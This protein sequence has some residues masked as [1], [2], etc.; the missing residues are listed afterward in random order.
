MHSYIVGNA[1]FT[2]ITEGV[3]RMEYA[4]NRS[5]VD[6][7][8]L[9][10]VRKNFFDADFFEENGTLTVKT[11]KFTLKYTDNGPFTAENLTCRIHTGGVDKIWHYGDSLSNN[12]FGTLVTLDGVNGERPLPDGI[13]SRDGFYVFDDSAK[14]VIFEGWIK[15]RSED[16]V[17]DIYLFAY[18]KDY[19]SALRDLSSVSG[20]FELPRRCIFGSWYSRWWKYTADE[21][22][23]I[24]DEYEKND[25]PLDIM[26][27]DMDWHYQDWGRNEGEPLALYGYGHCGQNLGWTG[28]T[29]NKTVIPDPPALISK[30]KSRGIKTVLNDHPADGLRDHDDGY[31]EFIEELSANGYTEEVPDI[32]SLISERE[33]KNMDRNVKNFRFNAG[34][35][36]YMDAFF[37]HALSRIEKD[38]AEF[39]WLDWQQDYIYPTVNKIK[40][41]PHLPWLNHLYYEHSK[42]GNKRGASFSRWGGI[43]D[44]KHPAY[45]SGDAVSSWETLAFEIKMTATA[46]NAGCFWWSHDIGGFVDYVEGGQAENYVRWVQFGA[47]SA[48]LRLH[49]NGVEGF[50][51]RPWTWGEPYCSAMREAFHLRSKLFPYI[52]SSAYT[53]YKKSLPFIRP[54]Y[55]ESPE[56][57]EAYEHPYTY[58]LGEHMIAS[59][60]VAPMDGD[61]AVT[62]LWLP[63]GEWVDIF[64]GKRYKSGN[65]EIEN[66]LFSFPL[67]VKVGVPFVTRPYCSRM[68]TEPYGELNIDIYTGESAEGISS[69]YEDDGESEEF[70]LGKCRITRMR[71]FSK[72]GEH[73]L[74]L[75]P[76]GIF[77]GAIENR[78]LKITFHNVGENNEFSASAEFEAAYENGNATV[79]FK[80]ISANEELEIILKTLK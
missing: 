42:N 79:I 52:Y 3:I 51:R 43:G 1:R 49:M 23:T 5:F 17:T 74:S 40:D 55:Y 57:N 25:F 65:V 66:G 37:E 45:F 10:A 50:D 16:S 67:F 59:P 69:L 78:D 58:F 27:M 8:T 28:Y 80:N 32:P 64:T 73:L 21:F 11:K 54:L 70:K 34:S 26:V 53:S 61:T 9:F 24:A 36:V 47:V 72:N 35:S 46:A 19:K 13:I 31:S 33:K 22:I 14:P 76:Q 29:W 20:E 4:E 41:L 18:G 30:L 62:R 56:C 71:Y 6:D 63:E 77:D 15:N 75:V 7:P 38:G 39:W 68:T 12:L 60:V 44:H 2:V 48:S